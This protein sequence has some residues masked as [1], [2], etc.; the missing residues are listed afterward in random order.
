MSTTQDDNLHRIVNFITQER[1]LDVSVHFNAF[2]DT[3]EPMGAECLYVSRY[4]PAKQVLH[5]QC[6]AGF[7]EPR[8]QKRT[9][10]FF[11]NYTNAPSI[12]IETCFVDSRAD[13]KLYENTSRAVCLA[14]AECSV[15]ASYNHCEASG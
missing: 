6:V 1:D 4:Q 12:L 14:I 11:L 13:A 2:E 7:N 9:D 8:R 15:Q 5:D 3:L 10:L